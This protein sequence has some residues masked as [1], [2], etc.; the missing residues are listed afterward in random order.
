M[1]EDWG[2]ELGVESVQWGWG[3]V[4]SGIPFSAISLA[5]FE[6]DFRAHQYVSKVKAKE[7][8]KD[9]ARLN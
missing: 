6:V 9:R 4:K 1:T 3:G 2:L 5:P 8:E 7:R